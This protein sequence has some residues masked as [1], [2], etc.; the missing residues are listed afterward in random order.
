MLNADLQK[1]F[2]CT[3]SNPPESIVM[4]AEHKSFTCSETSLSGSH[5]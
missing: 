1:L 3:L 5:C 4:L 2:H